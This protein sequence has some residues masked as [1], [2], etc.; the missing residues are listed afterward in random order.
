MWSSAQRWG[1][2]GDFVRP[3]VRQK[4]L[5]FC[6]AVF[7][8]PSQAL[9]VYVLFLRYHGVSIHVLEKGRVGEGDWFVRV[10]DFACLS[11][12]AWVWH[13]VLQLTWHFRFFLSCAY[14]AL[15]S[16]MRASASLPA[17]R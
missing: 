4:L 2:G 10:N 5:Q 14:K 8:V 3:L 12:C 16:A 15:A 11:V 17:S 6:V 9:V 13:R 7:L 1:G